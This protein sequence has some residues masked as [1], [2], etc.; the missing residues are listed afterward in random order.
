MR[1]HCMFLVLA[2][3]SAAAAQNSAP[4]AAPGLRIPGG[5]VPYALDRFADKPELV[6]VHHSAVQINNHKGANLAGSLAGSVFYKPKMTFE[7]DGVHARTVLHAATPSFYVHTMDDPG[8]DPTDAPVFAILHAIPDKDHRV[9]A[10]VAFTQLTG[11]AKRNDG[12]V[13]TTTERLPDGWLKVTPTAPLPPGE[14]A[15][16]PIAKAQ[17]AFST[18]VFD[19]SIDPAAPNASDAVLP[20]DAD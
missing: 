7:V 12:V 3:A 18:V 15:F 20:A 2:L 10:K 16:S 17:N 13:E 4:L 1:P 8:G 5:S 19:S 14:Y 11:N 6:P 9:F